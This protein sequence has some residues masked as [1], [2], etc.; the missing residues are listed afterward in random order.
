MS[1]RLGL[2]A[3]YSISDTY[4]ANDQKAQH[5]FSGSHLEL[6]FS[7]YL[8]TIPLK[9]YL[10]LEKYSR[11][12]CKRSE[13]FVQMKT[14][15]WSFSSCSAFLGSELQQI[16]ISIPPIYFLKAKMPSMMQTGK[17]IL[18]LVVLGY[19]NRKMVGAVGNQAE[20]YRGDYQAFQD[21]IAPP[22]ASHCAQ[23]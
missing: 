7:R 21:N 10:I 5:S 20:Y 6:L 1:E 14:S 18:D 23:S 11:M 2:L 8:Y 19:C 16:S 4:T 3:A 13:C 9:G 22:F 17:N 15:I 12:S